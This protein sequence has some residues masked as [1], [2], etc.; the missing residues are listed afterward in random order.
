MKPGPR[1]LPNNVHQLNGNPSNKPPRPEVKV[2]PIAPAMPKWLSKRGKA[3]WKYL[4]PELE[5]NALLTKRDREA[6]AFL[7][8]EAA[9]AQGALLAMRPVDPETGKQSPDFV[10]LDTDPNHNNRLRRHPALIIF[11]G[12]I[13]S[14]RRWCAEFGL[15]P[16][17]RVGLGVPGGLPPIVRDSDEDDEFDAG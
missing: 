5:K 17:S 12:A 3:N 10:L 6:F 11:N 13:A 14:Y 7:C 2:D 15:T 8:E 1:P 4:A 16:A 9:I